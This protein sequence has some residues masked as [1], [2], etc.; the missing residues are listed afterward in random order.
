MD[1]VVCCRC[2]YMV[3]APVVRFIRQNSFVVTL[4]ALCLL[5]FV[6]STVAKAD[7]KGIPFSDTFPTAQFPY[8]RTAE[9]CSEWRKPAH[10]KDDEWGDVSF[11]GACAEHDRCFHTLGLGWGECNERF[12]EDLQLT[13]DRDLKI[14]DL[15]KGIQKAPDAQA[16]ALCRQIAGLYLR[17]AQSKDSPKYFALAQAQQR[18]YLQYV[19]RVVSATY[20]AVLKRPATK[21]EEARA[22]QSL[23]KDLSLDDLKA[24]LM[25]VRMDAEVG[26]MPAVEML[27]GIEKFK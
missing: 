14:A 8:A 4:L 12:R 3:V 5:C 26:L 17:R 7:V 18:A 11:A 16:V 9:G 27:D 25:G 23:T 2:F 22:L 24:S 15:E 19:G 1:V 21:T 20:E 13:C 6:L 10:A